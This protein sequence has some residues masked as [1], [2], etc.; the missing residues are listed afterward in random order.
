VGIIGLTH[1]AQIKAGI[2]KPIP[3]AQG[4]H[5]KIINHMRVPM[6]VDGEPWI[7]APSVLD[8]QNT[9]RWGYYVD[10]CY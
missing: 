5:I 7:Q 4:R 2:S 9:E 6:Q 3:L 1:L 8:I 10:L